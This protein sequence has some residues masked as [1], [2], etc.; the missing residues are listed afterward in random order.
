MKYN[1]MITQYLQYIYYSFFFIIESLLFYLFIH[2]FP[3]CNGEDQ[4]M[5][6]LIIL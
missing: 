5:D 4:V 6:Y 3:I 2:L 1:R